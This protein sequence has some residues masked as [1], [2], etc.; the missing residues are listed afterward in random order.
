MKKIID[1]SK[2]INPYHGLELGP[3]WEENAR[4]GNEN[5]ILFLAVYYILKELKGN[6]T[7]EDI[8]NF[9]EICNRLVSYDSEGNRIPG[10][11]DRGAG[12][13]LTIAKEDLRTISH[14][15][16]SAISGFSYKHGLNHAKNIANY[17]LK[18]FFIYDNVNPENPRLERIQHPR[19]WYYWL[20]CGGKAYLGWVFFPIFFFANIITCLTPLQET[21]GKQL[22]FVRCEGIHKKSIGIWLTRFICYRILRK[23]YGK[24]WLNKIMNIYYNHAAHP[25]RIESRGIY[26]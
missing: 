12:E 24:D 2:W 3:D 8:S 17:G 20:L 15:N 10:L 16:L 4:Y 6:L 5:G 25:N 23:K 14:D 18:N 11:Y 9:N 22:M 1:E 21:S 19:D 26:L 13:S 7:S